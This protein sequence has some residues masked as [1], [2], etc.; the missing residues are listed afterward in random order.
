LL[1]LATAPDT[2]LFLAVPLKI[3]RGTG[4]PVRVLLLSA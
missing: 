2:G 4:S 3:Q 1:G